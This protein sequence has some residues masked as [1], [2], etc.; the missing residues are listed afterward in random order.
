MD[1]SMIDFQ[2]IVDGVVLLTAII[3]IKFSRES[4]MA[5]VAIFICMK[6]ESR[7]VYPLVDRN[8]LLPDL[9]LL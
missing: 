4:H 2:G 6:D 3:C 5:G 8:S 7:R 9:S 1:F